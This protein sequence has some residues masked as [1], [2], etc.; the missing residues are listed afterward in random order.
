[1]LAA[2]C[3][4]LIVASL[5]VGMLRNVS[6]IECLKA[7]PYQGIVLLLAACGARRIRRIAMLTSR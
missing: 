3:G 1:M 5:S 7:F 4:I 6:R 2:E